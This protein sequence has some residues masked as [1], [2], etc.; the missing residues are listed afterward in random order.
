MAKRAVVTGPAGFVGANLVRRLLAEGHEV[1]AFVHPQ[2]DLW[3]LEG[4]EAHIACHE[5]DLEDP[6]TVV[7]AM[8]QARPDWVFH[9]AAHGA[10]PYQTD[11][12]RM[13]A[14]NI[15]GT[16]NLMEAARARGFEAFVHAGSSSEYGLKDHAP[17]PD[18]AVE[19]NSYYALTKA[20]ATMYCRFVARRDDLAVRVL[21]L[22][23]VFGPWEE[24]TRLMPRLV[25]EG[26]AGRW[27]PMA[28][29]S[30]ARDYVYTDDVVDA[31]V[32]AATVEGQD[33]GAV[34]NVGTGFQTTLAEVTQVVRR[35]LGVE[36]EPA[37]GTMA[38]R[39]WDTGVWV[40][41]PSA[42]LKALG[43]SPR[44]DLAS[45]F[46]EMVAWLRRHPSLTDRYGQPAPG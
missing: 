3:R 5:V 34:Y 24:P 37:W 32:A 6:D 36:D 46:A 31:F 41:D 28:D 1:H 14:T 21:R 11:L 20:S 22:Y 17:G 7:R 39:I 19:P 43:W 30:T 25:V 8:N 9:A 2:S 33:P 27:P 15:M 10:Y 38:D 12:G 42:T 26:M 35:E 29:P 4:V 18:D 44:R 16:A 13:V 40:A 23:S 45:G